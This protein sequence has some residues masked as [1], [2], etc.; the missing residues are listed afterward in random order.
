[1]R[2]L[3]VA[4]GYLPVP[5][6]RGGAVEKHLTRLSEELRKLGLE[7]TIVARSTNARGSV[8]IG[9]MARVDASFA[10]RLLDS[11]RY[12]LAV[13]QYVKAN[14]FDIIHLHGGVAGLMQSQILQGKLVLTVHDSLMFS[15]A[16]LT[17]LI[18]TQMEVMSCRKARGIVCVSNQLRRVLTRRLSRTPIAWIPNGVDVEPIRSKKMAKTKLDFSE[19]EIVLFVGRIV[20]EKGLHVL[21]RALEILHF[22]HH[23]NNIMLV[24]AGPPGPTFTTHP[25]KYFEE[26][27]RMAR[28]LGIS[29]RY[30]GLVNE[31]VLKTLYAAADIMVVPSLAEANPLV[32]L[33]AM[34]SHVPVVASSLD[35]LLETVHDHETGILFP[36][37][38]HI[39]LADAL[40]EL[41]AD[42]QT[43][44]MIAGRALHRV[45]SE[46]GWSNVARRMLEFY[47]DVFHT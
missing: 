42:S 23:M 8:S 13:G 24:I 41:L 31:D 18:A 14:T 19:Y 47:N 39:A 2:V 38:D 28:S 11:A 33:E 5:S 32:V 40:Y 35:A 20:P 29:H 27:V 43:R 30:F 15:S 9:P 46:Y 36:A 22:K 26:T 21:I 34:A 25:T 16:P 45:K 4:P 10:M 1:M 17:R 6:P 12:S 7:V 3:Q 44:R 37:G